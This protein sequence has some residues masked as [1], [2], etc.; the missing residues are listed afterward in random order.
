MGQI[1]VRG[2]SEALISRWKERAKRHNRSLE[3]EIRDLLECEIGS[4]PERYAQAVRFAD[5][6]RHKYA[7]KITGNSADIIREAREERARKL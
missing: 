7:G 2:L 5:E 3:G 1:L 4:D 6:M